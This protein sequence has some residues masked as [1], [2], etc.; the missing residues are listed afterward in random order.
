MKIYPEDQ[1]G[2]FEKENLYTCFTYKI[3]ADQA[4]FFWKT[5]PML[6]IDATVFTIKK[7]THVLCNFWI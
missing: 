7:E 1:S 3:N 2:N 6:P 5:V 4:R